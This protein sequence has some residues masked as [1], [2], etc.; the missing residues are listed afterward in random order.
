MRYDLTLIHELCGELGLRSSARSNDLLEIELSQNAVLCFQ[1]AERDE[2]CLAGFKGTPW[3][4]HDDFLFD[5]GRGS[6]IEVNYLDILTGLKEGKVL[7]G[8][9]WQ[10]GKAL[11]RWLVHCEY[12][13][14]FKFMEQGEEIR[15]YRPTTLRPIS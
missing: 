15:A 10:K 13:D 11:D 8:E 14:E 5:D 6:F 9:R 12:N 7:I 1:N 3:H 4:T 2:G